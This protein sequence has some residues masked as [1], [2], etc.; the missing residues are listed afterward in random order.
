MT[1]LS[2]E[3]YGHYDFSAE[4][5]GVKVKVS[6]YSYESCNGIYDVDIFD[7]GL[8]RYVRNGKD[9][10]RNHIHDAIIRNYNINRG[11]QK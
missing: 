7:T 8:I 10:A 6:R 5:D 3:R 4:L 11:L 2:L 9:V 1:A